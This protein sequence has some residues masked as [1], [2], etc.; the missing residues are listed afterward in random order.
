[1]KLRMGLALLCALVFGVFVPTVLAGGAPSLG[2]TPVS[3]DYGT[4]DANTT[5]SQ[6]FVLKNSG[7]TATGML[8]ASLSGSSAFS[9]TAD[10]CT[11]T[12]LGPKKQCGVTVQY[13][14]T[15]AGSSDSGTLTVSGKKPAANAS[16]TL[17]G[18]S[19]PPMVDASLAASK[20]STVL[21]DSSISDSGD[22]TLH[23]GGSIGETIDVSIV[24]GGGSF[25]ADQESDT[26]SGCQVTAAF[27]T[28]PLLVSCEVTVDAGATVTLFSFATTDPATNTIYSAVITGATYTDP[29]TSNNKAT[30]NIGP[31]S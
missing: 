26:A 20:P 23:N 17:S 11:G 18:K 3:H 31:S 30:L 19:T 1:M 9:I 5:G 25:F 12:A 27:F 7:G 28:T 24:N 14:P 10:S 8:K 13:A 29:N 15:T 21:T 4:I 2:F 22:L 6:T 16:A